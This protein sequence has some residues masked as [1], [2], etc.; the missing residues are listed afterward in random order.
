MLAAAVAGLLAFCSVAKATTYGFRITGARMSE[1]MNFQGD[2][3][4]ACARAGVCGY[5]G[6]VSYRFDHAH[7]RAVVAI[8]RHSVFGVGLLF[9]GGLTTAT[10][11]VASG[12]APCTDALIRREDAFL[13]EGGS[14]RIRVVFHPPGTSID[15]LGTY[16]AG[17]SDDDMSHAGAVPQITLPTS[18]LRRKRL[19]LHVASTRGFHA[20]PF[21]GT[22]SFSA[23]IRLRR[24]RG[25]FYLYRL[26]PG[27]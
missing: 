13:V 26:V 27:G 19:F 18:A 12:G 22:L 20:G 11:Q 8:G 14:R 3:G 9:F 10:V 5:S 15:F 17:P 7:G 2:G 25:H 24:V 4:P 21:T 23:D 6:T 1:V 16:C